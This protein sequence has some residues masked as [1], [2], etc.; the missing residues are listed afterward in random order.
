M[1]NMATL[2][3]F[4]EANQV[5]KK[6]PG[7]VTAFELQVLKLYMLKDVHGVAKALSV[8]E[9]IIYNTFRRIRERRKRAQ[10][11]VNFWN[12]WASKDKRLF[13]VLTPK[14]ELKNPD[15]AED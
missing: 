7:I 8:T 12:G 14:P 5:A 6:F 13:M 3:D 1:R 11:T 15:E 10:H 2:E 9:Q 4:E